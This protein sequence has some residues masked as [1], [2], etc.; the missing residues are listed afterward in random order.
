MKSVS[1]DLLLAQAKETAFR[2]RQVFYKRR[3]W[4]SGDS[5]YVWE[6][7]WRNIET[8][9]LASS[10]AVDEDVLTEITDDNEHDSGPEVT[11]DV[12]DEFGLDGLFEGEDYTGSNAA[13]YR[14][15]LVSKVL[16]REYEVDFFNDQVRNA[17][18]GTNYAIDTTTYHAYR[19]VIKA[20][21]T[22]DLYVDGVFAANLGDGDPGVFILAA[23]KIVFE[24]V[25]YEV[26]YVENTTGYTWGPIT[27]DDGFITGKFGLSGRFTGLDPSNPASTD[28]YSIQAYSNAGRRPFLVRSLSGWIRL[29]CGQQSCTRRFLRLRRRH[30]RRP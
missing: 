13:Y 30:D 11:F 24:I 12:G 18:D 5:R 7:T 26:V 14:I 1:A 17:V 4:D 21:K 16:D 3:K 2:V 6:D 29:N 10:A 22:L 19:F 8:R 27:L 15:T 23:E 28:F 20:D 9:S 25:G